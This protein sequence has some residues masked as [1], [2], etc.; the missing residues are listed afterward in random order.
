MASRRGGGAAVFALAVSARA[1]AVSGLSLVALVAVTR[2]LYATGLV[3]AGL[4][5]VV[6]LDLVRSTRAADR[7]LAQFI[8][9]L[10]AEGYERAPS[11]PGLGEL[12][13]AVERA[14]E[15]LGQL[16]AAR[17]RRIEFL[18]ALLNT[19][20][21]ALLVVDGSGAA[22]HANRAARLR[23]KDVDGPLKAIAAFPPETVQRMLAM[24]PG[25]SEILRMAD[26]TQVLAQ[27]AEFTAG[28]SGRQ[29]LISLQGVSGELAPVELKAWQ[30]LVRILAHEMMNSLTAVCSIS[31][32]LAER[33]KA[34][35]APDELAA[36]AQAAEVVA[37]RSEGLMNFVDRYRRLMEMPVALKQRLRLAEPV[38]GLRRLLAD[39]FAA[40]GVA[41]E[42]VIAP[43]DLTAPV[44]TDLLEQALINLLKNALEAVRGRPDARVTLACR[45]EGDL[46]V[47]EVRDNG[48]GLPTDNPE[49]VFVPFYTTKLAGSGVGLTLARQVAQAHDGRLEHI[50]PD[51]GGALFRL[52]LPLA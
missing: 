22:T 45:A 43:T 11:L 23:F 47:I 34:G 46:A 37:R 29:R 24:R 16:R 33:L 7:A 35:S 3:V 26:Q 40:E 38:E 25:G 44:D 12:S 13:K 28:G 32:S 10:S 18:D 51:T 27:A 52:S 9:G 30:D 15:R 39:S 49:A 1:L 17:E 19:V 20:S 42:T 48:P 21:A 36:L 14:F 2:G 6:V 50:R 8:D 41:L 5:L 4:I 31:D